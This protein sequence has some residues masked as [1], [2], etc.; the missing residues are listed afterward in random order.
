MMHAVHTEQVGP[1]RLQLLQTGADIARFYVT[2]RHD[3]APN[4]VCLNF[5]SHDQAHAMRAVERFTSRARVEL[6]GDNAP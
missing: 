2:S 3:E 6:E 1:L 5:L 4:V